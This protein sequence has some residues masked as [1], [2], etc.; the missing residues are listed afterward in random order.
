MCAMHS[1]ILGVSGKLRRLLR[2]HSRA[3]VSSAIHEDACNNVENDTGALTIE[4][5]SPITK[6]E[7]QDPKFS[8]QVYLDNPFCNQV[9]SSLM[10]VSYDRRYDIKS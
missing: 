2:A 9:Q 10:T 8:R 4:I 7:S 6:S 1:S 3:S 5:P